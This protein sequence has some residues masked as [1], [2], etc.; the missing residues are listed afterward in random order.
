[1]IK[2]KSKKQ[3]AER[4]DKLEKKM[5]GKFTHR[6]K[7][8][9]NIFIFLV[10]FSSLA[11]F[12][13]II[14]WTHYDFSH[15][16]TI[17]S[18]FTSKVISVFGTDFFR[19]ENTF[20]INTKTGMLIAEII[21]DCVGWKSSLALISLMIATR[22]VST[23]ARAIGILIGIP[24]IFAGNI[25][26]LATTFHITYIYG[27]GFFKITHNILWQGGLIMLVIMTWWFWLEKIA[28]DKRYI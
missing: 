13:N 9:W 18:Y 23:K 26:R 27:L 28:T 22:Y 15:I 21:K 20:F 17:T 25:L 19:I 3:L 6:Q 5:T 11:I 16:I 10:R 4:F 1:M 8:M 12:L 2:K 24:I 14:L 7:K